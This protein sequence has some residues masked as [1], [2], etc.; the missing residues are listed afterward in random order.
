MLFS[1]SL[2]VKGCCTCRSTLSM[3]HKPEQLKNKFKV[4]L[5]QAAAQLLAENKVSLGSWSSMSVCIFMTSAHY[6]HDNTLH[7]TLDVTCETP[8]CRVNQKFQLMA[9]SLGVQALLLEAS[10]STAPLHIFL[11]ILHIMH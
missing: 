9:C 11:G 5:E 4:S 2:S 7:M 10:F 8:T 6:F 3:F 1:L